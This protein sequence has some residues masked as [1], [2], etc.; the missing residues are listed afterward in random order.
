MCGCGGTGLNCISV[1]I[2][3]KSRT[4]KNNLISLNLEIKMSGRELIRCVWHLREVLSEYVDL[5]II[6]IWMIIKATER[7]SITWERQARREEGQES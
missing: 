6:S 3:R 2:P 4:I 1:K 7:R 5:R